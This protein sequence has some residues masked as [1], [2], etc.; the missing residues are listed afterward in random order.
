MRDWPTGKFG[1]QLARLCREAG[2]GGGRG[3]RAGE[4]RGGGL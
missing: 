2:G 4:D 1:A 3:C